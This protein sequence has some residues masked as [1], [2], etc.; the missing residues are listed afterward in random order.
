MVAETP[1]EQS[2]PSEVPK[3]RKEI[4]FM[5]EARKDILQLALHY[6]YFMTGLFTTI[7]CEDSAD[8]YE[9]FF[10][11][12]LTPGRRKQCSNI[13]FKLLSGVPVED[14]V[15]MIGNDKLNRQ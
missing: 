10:Y 14:H 7:C 2:F 8:V 4:F 11:E 13:R 1:C 15:W 12:D 6:M 9:D 3:E 5:L